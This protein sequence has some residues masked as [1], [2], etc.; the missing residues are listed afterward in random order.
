MP[1][2]RSS[3]AVPP[4]ATAFSTIS[5]AKRAEASGVA[6]ALKASTERGSRKLKIRS[7][8]QKSG[9]KVTVST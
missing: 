5:T 8:K 9:L 4:V 7:E 2:N 1:L 6:E 3:E